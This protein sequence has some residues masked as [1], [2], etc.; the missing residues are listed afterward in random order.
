MKHT[1]LPATSPE[2][3]VPL[4]NQVLSFFETLLLAPPEA[5]KQSSQP[6]VR[7]RR[8]HPVTLT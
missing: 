5:G 3:A 1:P 8:G 2:Q 6:P 4:I 7:Q